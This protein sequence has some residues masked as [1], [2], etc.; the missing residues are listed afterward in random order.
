MRPRKMVHHLTHYI[1]WTLKRSQGINKM[2]ATKDRL[3]EG[4]GRVPS[5]NL[6]SRGFERNL[7]MWL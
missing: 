1:E 2:R 4:S 5:L 7:G 6:E 3:V